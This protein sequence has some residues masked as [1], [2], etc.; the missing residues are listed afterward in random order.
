MALALYTRLSPKDPAASNFVFNAAYYL[1]WHLVRAGCSAPNGHDGP[2]LVRE[3]QARLRP[4][5]LS[6]QSFEQARHG[7]DAQVVAWHNKLPPTLGF[8]G[9]R[10]SNV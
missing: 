7:L 6:A 8:E 3:L 4:V 10:A 5:V 2:A 1:V 9:A